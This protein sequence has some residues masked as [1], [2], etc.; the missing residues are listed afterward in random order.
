MKCEDCL[1]LIEA[2]F[3]D[4]PGEHPAS[5]IARHTLNCAECARAFVEMKREQ[6]LYSL[7]KIEVTPAL[8]TAVHAR[9]QEEQLVPLPRRSVWLSPQWWKETIFPA[10]LIPVRAMLAILMAVGV[11]AFFVVLGLRET[12]PAAT[13][14]L[15]A[16]RSESQ[17]IVPPAHDV[18]SK[19]AAPPDLGA[20][21]EQARTNINVQTV[22]GGKGANLTFM[23]KARGGVKSLSRSRSPKRLSDDGTSIGGG[24]LIARSATSS[25]LPDKTVRDAEK[26]YLDAITIVSRD[27]NRRIARLHPVENARYE[28]AIKVVDKAIADTR[29]AVR[30]QPDDLVAVQYMLSSY[31]RKVEVLRDMAGQ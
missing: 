16:A 12:R 4:L 26:A 10:R 7:F 24:D 15:V 5:L 11:I 9:I 22:S 2:H 18:S 19:I 14:S 30:E 8:W 17:S 21:S 28:E 3:D 23:A 20:S 29:R 13:D 31:A 27:A 1:S 25:P 6:E